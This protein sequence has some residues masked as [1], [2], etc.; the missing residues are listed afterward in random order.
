M[1]FRSQ[2]LGCTPGPAYVRPQVA[3]P[4]QFKEA[5][6]AAPGWQPAQP[7]DDVDRGTWW[8]LFGDTTLDDL[9]AK[10][11]VGNQ[12]IAR[13]VANLA[14]AKALVGTARSAYWPTVTAGASADRNHTSQNVVG[15]SLAGKTVIEQEDTGSFD[16]FVAKYNTST[17]CGNN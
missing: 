11:D 15:R 9:E 2:S 10:V 13:S 16:D 8:T 7:G 1:L 4:D 5:S 14:Q 3:V 12:T 6:R 17:L